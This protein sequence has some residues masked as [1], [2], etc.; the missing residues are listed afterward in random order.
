MPSHVGLA[1]A[2]VWDIQG[3]TVTSSDRKLHIQIVEQI[4]TP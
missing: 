2:D 1:A 3:T 4:D